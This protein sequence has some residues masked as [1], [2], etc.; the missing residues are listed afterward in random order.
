MGDGS[1][2]D[3]NGADIAHRYGPQQGGYVAEGALY[4]GNAFESVWIGG[5][6][7]PGH[8]DVVARQS[9][10]V[11]QKKH[12]GSDGST[13]TFRGLDPAELTVTV[14]IWTPAQY[15]ELMQIIGLIWPK[16]NKD[17]P[18]LDAGAAAGA[19]IAA[20]FASGIGAP[21]TAI[22]APALRSG[23]LKARG[24]FGFKSAKVAHLSVDA[25]VVQRVSS[26]NPD[27]SV[28][29][30]MQCTLECVQYIPP[31]PVSATVT[32]KGAQAVATTKAFQPKPGSTRNSAVKPSQAGAFGP[33]GEPTPPQQGSS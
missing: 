19:A 26:L 11:Q 20:A 21:A 1:F 12:N 27:T 7:L 22:A 13:P 32:P 28:S 2:W 15:A 3:E 6:Q 23:G 9:Q 25:V 17:Q 33:N 8:C 30:V 31:K 18:E 5:M 4:P 24:A 16:P 14:R 10:R 29:G